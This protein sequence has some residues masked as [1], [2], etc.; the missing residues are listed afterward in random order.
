MANVWLA[1]A[2]SASLRL[3]SVKHQTVG[4][5]KGD[6]AQSVFSGQLADVFAH[7]RRGDLSIDDV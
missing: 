2:G 1:R 3:E 5:Q 4:S 7:I 6:V